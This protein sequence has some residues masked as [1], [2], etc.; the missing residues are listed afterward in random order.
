MLELFIVCLC[1]FVYLFYAL[2][3]PER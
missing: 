2:L 1:L 3:Y